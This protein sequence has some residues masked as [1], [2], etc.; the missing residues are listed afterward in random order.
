[1]RVLY[2]SCWSERVRWLGQGVVLTRQGY[3]DPVDFNDDARLDT[4]QISDQRGRRMGGG[5]IALGGG[6]L[7]IVGLIVALL[8]G[9]NPGDLTG[10]GGS[11]SQ[12]TVVSATDLA[13]ECRTGAD[14][15]T[16]ED[17]RIVGVVNSVQKYWAGQLAGRYAASQTQLFTGQTS[18]G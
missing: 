14:A 4:S 8:L 16:K 9:V 3:A 15:D 1:M 17:C 10:G 6:G 2:G 5:G 13:Q 12:D 7:G 18:T 11:D